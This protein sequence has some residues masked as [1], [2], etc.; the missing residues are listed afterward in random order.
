ML[1]DNVFLPTQ[2]C[3]DHF[4][5]TQGGWNNRLFL[6]LQLF[7]KIYLA[8]RE[9]D[10]LIPFVRKVD[11]D[12]SAVEYFRLN[13][14][15]EKKDEKLKP[16]NLSLHS[17]HCNKTFFKSIQVNYGHL[18]SKI[19]TPLKWRFWIHTLF[20]L[21]SLQR[22][23]LFRST[24]DLWLHTFKQVQCITVLLTPWSIPFCH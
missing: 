19:K 18:W 12:L 21:K 9:K 3:L 22:N 1:Y 11:L 6:H 5:Q 10:K 24:I 2:Y 16:T 15:G 14:V 20:K 4:S 7:K 23:L 13:T 8:L 17:Y